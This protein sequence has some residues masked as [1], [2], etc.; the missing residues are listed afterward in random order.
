MLQF[1]SGR[2]QFDFDFDFNDNNLVLVS[3]SDAPAPENSA[4]AYPM[5]YSQT[6]DSNMFPGGLAISMVPP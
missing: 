1:S 3:A 5:G 4:Q 6:R 2:S